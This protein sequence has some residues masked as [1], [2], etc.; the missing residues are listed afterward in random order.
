MLETR[1]ELRS[2]KYTDGMIM[3]QTATTDLATIG[4]YYSYWWENAQDTR[5]PG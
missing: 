2:E 5:T 4:S 3:V 1:E